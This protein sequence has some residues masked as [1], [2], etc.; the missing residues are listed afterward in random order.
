MPL[1]VGLCV[2]CILRPSRTYLPSNEVAFWVNFVGVIEQTRI[3]LQTEFCTAAQNTLSQDVHLSVCLSHASKTL[4]KFFHRLLAPL[5]FFRIPRDRPQRWH[6][7]LT[8]FGQQQ[9]V[10]SEHCAIGHSGRLEKSDLLSAP[11][12]HIQINRKLHMRYRFAP[13]LMTLNYKF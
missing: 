7:K 6:G 8:T 12:R 11:L 10:I 13:R 2:V 5:F 3:G 4:L 9:A 1:S